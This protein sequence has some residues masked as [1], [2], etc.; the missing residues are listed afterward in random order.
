MTDCRSAPPRQRLTLAG[1]T[2]ISRY[3][4]TSGRVVAEARLIGK[5]SRFGLR[6]GFK[7]ALQ[8]EIVYVA[9]VKVGPWGKRTGIMRAYRMDDDSALKTD[10]TC[11]A[12][13]MIDSVTKTPSQ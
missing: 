13:G 5:F 4:A 2:S 12:M 8:W 11:F 1:I 10:C 7:G 3:S 9:V 6:G